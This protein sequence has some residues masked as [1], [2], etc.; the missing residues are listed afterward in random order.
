[1]SELYSGVAIKKFDPRAAKAFC[2]GMA[3]R[4]SD[5]ALN[6]PSTDNPFDV[7]IEFDCYEGWAK[8]WN[9]ADA[10]AGGNLTVQNNRSC[11]VTGAVQI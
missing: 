3:Y 5:T 7:T 11:N 2:D 4:Q 6:A 8:G 10:L 9:E 1:M